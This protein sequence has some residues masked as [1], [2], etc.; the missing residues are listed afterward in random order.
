MEPRAF[1]EA[2]AS[3]LIGVDT[4]KLWSH[5]QKKTFKKFNM[6]KASE[7]EVAAINTEVNAFYAQFAKSMMNLFGKVSFKRFNDFVDR[8]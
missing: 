5:D 6:A 1:Q 7:E 4:Q 8:L 3:E 2:F